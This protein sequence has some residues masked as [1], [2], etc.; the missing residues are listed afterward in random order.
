MKPSRKDWTL[1]LDDALWA[2]MTA[3][4]TPIGMSHFKLVYGKSCHLLVELEHTAMWALK[5]FNM[6]LDEAGMKRMM[7][8]KSW[9]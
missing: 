6:D 2:Y 9:K 8:L 1:K 3:Y 5:E 4:K 7:D